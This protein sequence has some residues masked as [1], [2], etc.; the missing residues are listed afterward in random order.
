M[1]TRRI[2]SKRRI[3]R[4][5]GAL[6]VLAA[7]AALML[8]A[9]AGPSP[10]AKPDGS[11]VKARPFVWKAEVTATNVGANALTVKVVK[12]RK[13]V[14]GREITCTLAGK[15]VIMKVGDDGAEVVSLGAVA[16]G[17]RVLVHGRVDR[18][19]PA[20][21]VYTAWLILDRGPVLPR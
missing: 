16:V 15:A 11:G 8:A 7:A 20:A 19:S 3:R 18:T 13:A 4:P 10:A 2:G 21:P 12:G 17:D 14:V 5:A 1:M 9:V 6:V